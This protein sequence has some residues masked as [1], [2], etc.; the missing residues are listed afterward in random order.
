MKRRPW[1]KIGIELLFAGFLILAIASPLFAQTYIDGMVGY[2]PRIIYNGDFLKGNANTNLAQILPRL[3]LG[4]GYKAEDYAEAYFRLFTLGE[5]YSLG[6]ASYAG[7]APG[8]PAHEVSLTQAWF[9][10]KIPGTPIHYR[11]GRFAQALGHGFYMNS[12]PYGGDGMKIWAP[13]GGG[14]IDLGY[15]KM[16][17]LGD[18]SRDIDQYFFRALVPVAERHQIN[19]A[20]QWFEGRNLNIEDNHS[21]RVGRIDHLF[22]VW[23]RSVTFDSHIWTL[24]VAMD[25]LIDVISYR[26]EA[27]YAGGKLTDDFKKTALAKEQSMSGFALLAGTTA[28]LGRATVSLEG[29]FGSGDKRKKI[30]D[31]DDLRN[32]GSGSKYEGF[33]VPMAQWGRSVFLDEASFFPPISTGDPFDFGYPLGGGVNDKGKRTATWNQR[34]LENLIYLS[35]GATYTPLVPVTLSIEVFKF[36]A[37]RTTPQDGFDPDSRIVY[38]RKQSHDLGWE[39]DLTAKWT[40]NKNFSINGTFAPWIPGDYFKVP[41]GSRYV[42]VPATYDPANPATFSEVTDTSDPKWGYLLRAN[43]TFAF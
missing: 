29:A 13:I 20:I 31:A 41:K 5:G 8:G 12:G 9:D 34:G 33:K 3:F 39:I 23:D 25:G 26:A 42:A 32:F 21:S 10:V 36:W 38:S 1:R 28:N 43:C 16:N 6:G 7:T 4:A 14:R 27:V 18:L 2:R 15:C 22:T 11:L 19:A 30:E 37:A 40:L 35:I 24:G 17:E